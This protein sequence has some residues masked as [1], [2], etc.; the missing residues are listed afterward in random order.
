[1]LVF[2]RPERWTGQLIQASDRSCQARTLEAMIMTAIILTSF[3]RSGILP[4]AEMASFQPS[5]LPDLS[6]RQAK[7]AVSVFCQSLEAKGDAP[8]DLMR[9]IG[10]LINLRGRAR[11]GILIAQLRGKVRES[12]LR[13]EADRFS[14]QERDP[15]FSFST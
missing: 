6:L 10:R 1:M 3:R 4:S 11:G 9:V 13:K 7:W 15:G 8:D 2:T 14:K 12:I 5:P